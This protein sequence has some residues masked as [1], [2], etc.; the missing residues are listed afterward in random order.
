MT[1]G[2]TIALTVQTFDGKLM[3]LLFNMLSRLVIVFFFFPPKEQASFNFMAAAAICSDSLLEKKQMETT[4]GQH[5]TQARGSC[6]VKTV[7]PRV[8][9]DGRQSKGKLTHLLDTP[10]QAWPLCIVTS[11]PQ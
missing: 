2:K 11:R 8:P 5:L 3:S 10:P 6:A 9:G 4:V 1:T 7:L